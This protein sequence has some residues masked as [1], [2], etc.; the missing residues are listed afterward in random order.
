M[1]RRERACR[2]GLPGSQ[3]IQFTSSRAGAGITA[4]TMTAVA[5]LVRN[6]AAIWPKPTRCGHRKSCRGALIAAG[7]LAPQSGPAAW[8]RS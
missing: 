4:W 1:P 7:S 3:G 2:P 6:I 5:E 8:A